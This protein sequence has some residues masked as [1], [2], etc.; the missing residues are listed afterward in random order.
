MQHTLVAVFDNRGDAD[1]ALEDLVASGF[2]RWEIQVTAGAAS[3]DAGVGSSIRNFFSDVFGTERG[4][5]TQMYTEAVGRGHFVLT[6]KADSEPEVERAAAIVE[7]YGPIDID[8]QAEYRG[9]A[10]E[11][12]QRAQPGAQQRAAE[13]GTTAI[14]VV[15]EQLKVG[16]REVQ[17]GGVRI[18]QRL[19]ETPVSEQVDLREEH[20]HVERHA[21]DRPA[22]AQDLQAFE[23]STIELHEMAEEPV[24]EK[25]ARVVEE[26]VV[27]KQVSE[28]SEA[29]NETIRRTEVDV[30]R[31]GPDDE[32][33]FRGHWS[34]NYRSAGASY[35]E[36]EP[37]Y[38]YGRSMA[39]SE[40]YRGRPWEDVEGG[41]RSD[42][43][44]RNPSSG[45]DKF[46]AAI[47]HGWERI[48]S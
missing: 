43:E 41:L 2:S 4:Q 19:V 37:A 27:G 17:R 34:S 11:T 13:G 10:P 25:T 20:V 9:A 21:V 5:A 47:K 48:T 23:E 1:K 38:D 29:I 42:W 7:R 6:A 18:F 15:E 22:G 8:E 24:I 33:S 12:L 44:S 45:W 3:D 26:V 14:P 30:E 46:K 36:Y 35:D 28:R 31:L 39:R 40:L 32:A 16:K